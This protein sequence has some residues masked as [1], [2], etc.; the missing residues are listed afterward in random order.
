MCVC[1]ECGSYD[2]GDV[3]WIGN[4]TR[5]RLNSKIKMLNH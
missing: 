3:R 2:D 4:V 5:L 1:C